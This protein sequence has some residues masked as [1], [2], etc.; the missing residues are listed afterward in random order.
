MRN[1]GYSEEQIVEFDQMCLK[2]GMDM[3]L[4]EAIEM[5]FLLSAVEGEF[6]FMDL[7]RRE[8]IK[9]QTKHDLG[10]PRNLGEFVIKTEPES[11]SQHKTKVAE[12]IKMKSLKKRE[13][14]STQNPQSRLPEPKPVAILTNNKAI[15]EYQRLVYEFT[16]ANQSVKK[17]R[18]SLLHE[19]EAAAS[20]LPENWSAGFGKPAG[21][22]Q[23]Q[24]SPGQEV[25]VRKNQRHSMA[26]AKTK[27]KMTGLPLL[28]DGSDASSDRTLVWKDD[29][30][31]V[32]R[33]LV[34][35]RC[36]FLRDQQRYLRKRDFQ[37]EVRDAKGMVYS[38]LK[39]ADVKKYYIDLQ[40]IEK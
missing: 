18:A 33:N 14:K 19:V 11:I 36:E 38:K 40:Q 26:L 15:N 28:D 22:R 2:S 20:M 32:A 39:I 13:N 9:E 1:E 25:S 24:G 16:K 10:S 35:E 31:K 12:K 6:D 27:K 3:T 37:K 4:S 23:D 30:P 17:R 29:W 5:P 21:D 7:K 8:Y 34:N